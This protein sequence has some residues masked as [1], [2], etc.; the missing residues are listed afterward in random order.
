[1]RAPTSRAAALGWRVH[2]HEIT[3]S[4]NL[5]LCEQRRHKWM[6][7][8][9]RIARCDQNHDRNIEFNESLLIRKSTIHGHEHVKVLSS[10]PEQVSVL[11]SRPPGLWN[12]LNLVTRK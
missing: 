2:M 8:R 6:Q 3:R 9:Q 7:D 1:M 10:D 11:P 4:D 12:S 5:Q